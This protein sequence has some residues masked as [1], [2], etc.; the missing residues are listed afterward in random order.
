[1]NL[2][3]FLVVNIP[4]RPQAAMPPSFYTEARPISP[5]QVESVL[6]MCIRFENSDLNKSKPALTI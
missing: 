1:M 2:G 6:Q 3:I 4:R 5:F